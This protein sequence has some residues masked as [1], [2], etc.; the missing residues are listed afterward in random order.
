MRK[1][2]FAALL[3][4]AATVLGA[5][6]LREPVADAATAT[7]N[8]IV[9]NDSSHPVPVQQQGTASVSVNN[10]VATADVDVRTA[11]RFGPE[12]FQ[13]AGGGFQ[14]VVIPRD[15]IPAGKKF[16]VAYININGFSLIE[17][18][19]LA[20]GQCFTRL[21]TEGE[22]GGERSAPFVAVPLTPN[23]GA[24]LAGSE[25]AFLPLNSGEGLAFACTGQ[26]ATGARPSSE[27]LMNVGGY[28]V[29]T[30]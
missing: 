1:L 4:V 26:T 5:T 14:E 29:S 27:F 6:V 15:A 18:S 20:D 10:T 16:I 12:S 24:M 28:F 9:Q 2:S 7:L 17:P 25:P 22:G 23:D 3:L 8:V 30:P 21:L 11:V 13:T 19:P